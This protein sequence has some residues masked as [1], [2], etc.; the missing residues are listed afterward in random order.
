MLKNFNLLN[1]KIQLFGITTII[2][3]NNNLN[4]ISHVNDL[5][6]IMLIII[7]VNEHIIYL[8]VG[9]VTIK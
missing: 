2:R 5:S 4:T 6:V 1:V 9:I 8:H 3:D 7:S